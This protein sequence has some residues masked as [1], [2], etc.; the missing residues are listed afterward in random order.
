[1]VEKFHEKVHQ[2]IDGSR[3]QVHTP[4]IFTSKKDSESNINDIRQ[5]ECSVRMYEKNASMR[6]IM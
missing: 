3:L 1:M 4:S 6:K 2:S 5:L